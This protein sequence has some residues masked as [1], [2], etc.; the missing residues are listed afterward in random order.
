MSERVK[1]EMVSTA[2]GVP[3]LTDRQKLEIYRWMVLTREVDDRCLTL[4]KQGRL[5]G[6]TFSGFGHEA[7]AVTAAYALDDGDAGGSE[8]ESAGPLLTIVR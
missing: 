1:G 3:A 5:P 7:I 2:H 4:F 8:P 6:G